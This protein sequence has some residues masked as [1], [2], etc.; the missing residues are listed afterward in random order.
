MCVYI[1]NGKFTRKSDEIKMIMRQN[2]MKTVKLFMKWNGVIMC[3]EN[4]AKC[5]S[6]KSGVGE[7]VMF[8][9]VSLDTNA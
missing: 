8:D 4:M 2:E 7:C 1:S 3:D 6:F 5:F 9:V